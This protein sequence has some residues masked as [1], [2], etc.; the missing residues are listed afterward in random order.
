MLKETLVRPSWGQ[1]PSGAHNDYSLATMHLL[2]LSF[3]RAILRM[4]HLHALQSV[5]CQYVPSI[6]F[7]LYNM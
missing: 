3:F 2:T 5:N 7:Y 1:T 4:R 6:Q